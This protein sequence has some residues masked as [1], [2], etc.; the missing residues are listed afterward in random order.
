MAATELSL[1]ES[2]SFS[3]DDDSCFPN[4]TTPIASGGYGQIF[5]TE[6]PDVVCKIFLRKYHP[7][8]YDQHFLTEIAALT[9]LKE[10]KYVPK[11]HS[12]DYSS[13]YIY[14]EKFEMDLYQLI[15]SGKG[16]IKSRIKDIIF[17]ILLGLRDAHSRGIIHQD[18]KPQ[19]ILVSGERVVICDWG[20]SRLAVEDYKIGEVQSMRYRAPE[21]LLLNNNYS[22]KIDV[23]SVGCILVEM[24]RYGKIL[25]NGTNPLEILL[26]ILTYIGTPDELKIDYMPN[27]V[28]PSNDD[29]KESKIT[30]LIKGLLD[31]NPIK[32]F[33]VF[34]AL[35]HSFFKNLILPPLKEYVI[36]PIITQENII[37]KIA[38]SQLNLRENLNCRTIKLAQI[39]YEKCPPG[40]RFGYECLLLAYIV[41]E[42]SVRITTI[43]DQQSVKKLAERLNGDLF[44][45]DHLNLIKESESTSLK[46]LKM[47]AEL[48]IGSIL[49]RDSNIKF[50][51]Y[52]EDGKY[53]Y[54]IVFVSL[55][56]GKI[57]KNQ[58]LNRESCE[59]LG[60][61]MIDSREHC[62]TFDLY[63][64]YLL[65]RDKIK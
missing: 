13:N 35:N 64:R 2:S 31:I 57:I 60:V 39:Y 44:Q 25:F 58:L 63:P 14:T 41:N 8:V 36:Q 37:W 55:H 42:H 24:I 32:R 1:S 46:P 56:I 65:F 5:S 40:I 43:E 18:I 19:N 62:A 29:H 52:Y 48:K 11:I 54:F 20:G 9:S 33:S 47:S 49:Y 61:K 23:W 12:I 30:S 4:I 45:L 34:E 10:S 59:K 22:S 3:S 7:E 21:V 38:L 27:F 50:S 6:N 26:S 15:M 16:M 51:H 28:K 17:Q 53:K